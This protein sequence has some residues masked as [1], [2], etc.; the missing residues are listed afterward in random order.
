MP[1]SSSSARIGAIV[2]LA[3]VALIMPG[4][5]LPMFT[6]SNP[7]IPGSAHPVFE[8]QAANVDSLNL[9][10]TVLF[11]LLA[12]LPFLGMILVLGT[13]LAA[14]YRIHAPEH[15][16][17]SAEIVSLRR[18]AAGWGLAIQLLFDVVVFQLFLIG[19]ARI[20]I[21]WGFVVVLIG[22]IVTVIGACVVTSHQ[23]HERT[24]HS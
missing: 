11:G 22:F 8:W 1:S 20:D 24:N 14:L 16:I 15:F 10:L 7:Q 12:A 3:G 17:H 19:Y 2:S 13:S 18:V 9:G 21:A 23:S 5:F 4:F 6:E